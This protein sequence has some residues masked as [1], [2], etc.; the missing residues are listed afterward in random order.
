MGDV[1]LKVLIVADRLI[2]TDIW[3]EHLE[4]NWDCHPLDYITIETD[5]PD[6]P[7]FYGDEIT[8]FFGPEDEIIAAIKEA[9]LFLTQLA[10]ISQKV[11]NAAE[12]L[13]I[14]GCC[15]T[16]P[17]NIN[18]KAATAGGIPVIYAPGR[19]AT[20]V[21]EFTMG[22]ILAEIKN[23]SRAH[24]DLKKGIW[25]GDF[26][27]YDITGPELSQMTV[28]LIGFGAIGKLMAPFFKAFGSE[29]VVYDPYIHPGV[30]KEFQLK[31]VGFD[32]LL[33]MADIVSLHARVTPETRGMMGKREFSLMKRGAYFVNT[34]RGPL[35][36]YKALYQALASW[37]LAGAALDCFEEEPI[38][39]G[40][41][42]FNLDNVTIT[43][44]I[45][46]SS[47]LTAHRAAQLVSEDIHNYFANQ[48]LQHCFN[49]EVV[50][51]GDQPAGNKE[52]ICI[53][54]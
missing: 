30:I 52:S 36:D 43:P 37:H 25:R 49:L 17:V 4:K 44:H 45:A 27:R 48:P 31:M 11:L 41:P 20:A 13:K 21:A 50:K 47:K 3:K 24:V 46:G 29:I 38:P 9:D 23:I 16:G 39:A 33:Q 40:N 7:F 8:E 54:V 1:I 18:V 5:W 51:R 53:K 2:T 10:P 19:N 34:A 26:Y 14:I 42:L 15:R 28:G 6:H 22:L 35:V 12:N 32:E